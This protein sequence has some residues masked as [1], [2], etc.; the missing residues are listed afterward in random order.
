[1][2]MRHIFIIG[3]TCVLEPNNQSLRG[4]GFALPSRLKGR[5]P[6]SDLLAPLGFRPC[7]RLP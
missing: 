4:K 2:V 6:I 7:R 5:S 1:M 3:N